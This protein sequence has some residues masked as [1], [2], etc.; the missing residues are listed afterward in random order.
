MKNFFYANPSKKTYLF[1][2]F[3]WRVTLTLI[4]TFTIHPDLLWAWYTQCYFIFLF[5]VKS[6]YR[7]NLHNM[8]SSK[9]EKVALS[10][11]V[12]TK[13]WTPFFRWIEI[14]KRNKLKIT[15]KSCIVQCAPMKCMFRPSMRVSFRYTFFHLCVLVMRFRLRNTIF[16]KL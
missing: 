9:W 15:K 14:L 4:T 7:Q 5:H 8:K 11:L 16:R 10:I 6:S 2:Y 1:A 12:D 3:E 13:F